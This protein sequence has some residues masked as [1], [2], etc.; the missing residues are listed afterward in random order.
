MASALMSSKSIMKH[1]INIRRDGSAS[2]PGG[3]TPVRGA[4]HALISRTE[5]LISIIVRY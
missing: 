4:Q 3:D 5:T 1:K 2:S